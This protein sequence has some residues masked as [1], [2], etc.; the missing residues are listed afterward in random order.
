VRARNAVLA[1]LA[2]LLPGAAGA[3]EFEL[4]VGAGYFDL[5][6]AKNSAKA[7]FGSSGGFTFGGDL[8]VT[9]GHNLYLGVGG[10]YFKKNGERA[11]VASATGPV[12]PLKNEPLSARLIPL[13]AT[14]GYRFRP[15]S[16]IGPYVGIGPGLTLYREESTVG[17]VTSTFS[18]TK[19]SGHAL[20]GVE[21]GQGE[22]RFGLEVNFSVVPNAIGIGG[23]SQVYNEK[24]IGGLAV[25]GRLTFLS[26]RH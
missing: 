3:Q 19:F 15:G 7:I 4:G 17:G 2:V 11:F 13:E 14:I 6:Q 22:V 8:S 26:P 25:L 5:T 24:D 21:F 16:S 1:L 23:V 20:A 9:L 18:E 12:F 10:R